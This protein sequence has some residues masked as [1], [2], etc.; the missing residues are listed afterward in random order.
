MW[1]DTI[2]DDKQ[3]NTQISGEIRKATGHHSKFNN[4]FIRQILESIGYMQQRMQ[5]P[6][7]SPYDSF[8]RMYSQGQDRIYDPRQIDDKN[9]DKI[10]GNI[11]EAMFMTLV[12]H[13]PTYA[14][15]L[16]G[17]GLQCTLDE[18]L[19]DLRDRTERKL[20]MQ[21]FTDDYTGET[22]TL[23]PSRRPPLV[24]DDYEY[25][26]DYSETSSTI[27]VMSD[28]DGTPATGLTD[29]EFDPDEP[30]EVNSATVEAEDM[31]RKLTTGEVQLD[32]LLNRS[33]NLQSRSK[34]GSSATEMRMRMEPVIDFT[35]QAQVEFQTSVTNSM[36]K[37]L[38]DPDGPL[39]G[40]IDTTM[41]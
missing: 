37:Q 21:K 33:D 14:K 11:G 40:I 4:H 15:R 24:N 22:M 13:N 23:T 36:L 32:D 5:Y 19:V 25:W 10:V 12:E 3:F 17:Y 41:V 8:S 9:L 38:K 26:C 34:E 6:P 1:Y 27:M 28:Y 2:A 35:E 39:A 29:F 20:G 7:T 30:D 31:V 18:E 16:L